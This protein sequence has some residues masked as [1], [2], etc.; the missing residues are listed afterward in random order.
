MLILICLQ[1]LLILTHGRCTLCTEHIIGSKIILTHHMELQGGVDNVVSHFGPLEIVLV[2]VQDRCMIC[3]KRTI[4][5]EIILDAPIGT[6][7]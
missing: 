4:G 2:S 1:I 3:A 5:I 6:P 7:W